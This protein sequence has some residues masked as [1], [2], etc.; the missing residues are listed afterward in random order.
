[1]KLDDVR[2]D[3]F[4]ESPPEQNATWQ[5]CEPPELEWDENDESMAVDDLLGASRRSAHRYS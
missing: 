3:D 4:D 5:D 2:E 1:M